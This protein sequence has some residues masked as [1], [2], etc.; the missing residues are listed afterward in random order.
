MPAVTLEIER[1]EPV[2]DGAAFGAAGP[3]EKIAG[4]LRFAID[5]ALPVH[6]T[7]AD[8]QLAPRNA[9]GRVESSAD[10]YLLRPVG[11]GNRR[12]LLDVPN[13]GRKMA[14]GMFNSTPRSN[15]PSN[16]EDF[17]NGFLMRHGYTVAWVGWQPDVP[18]QDGMMALTV[19]R[20]TGT[21]GRIRCEFRPNARTDSLPLADRY[22]IP[23]PVAQ[24]EDPEHELTVRAHAGAPDVPVPRSAWRFARA[25]GG[26]LVADRSCISLAGGFE[27]GKIYECYYRAQDPPVVGLGFT[28]VRD[29]AAFLR[30]GS[31]EAGNPCPGGLDRAYVF[32]VSQS[33]R[34]LRHLLYLGLDE[35]EAGR[36]VFDAVIPHVAGARR[37]EFNC[38]F[39]QPSLSGQRSIGSL[40][41]FADAEQEDPLTGQRG[42]L[43]ER[44]RRRGRVPKIFTINGSAE[45]WRG[46][47]S[48]VHT[49]VA[50]QRDIEPPADVRIYLFAGTQHTP[51]A[52][53]PPS[54]DANTGG[55]GRHMFSPVDYS[56]LLRAALVNLDL[57]VS[58]GTEPPG[59]MFPRIADG[60]A[61]AAER[62]RKVFDSIPGVA[63]PDRVVRPARLDFGAEVERGIISA[64]PPKVG[65]P[66]VTFVSAV[67]ADG[68]E[69][70]G[71]RPMEIRVPLATFTGWNPRHPDQGVP[72]DLMSMMGSTFPLARTVA[73]RD[74]TK[75]PRPSIGERYGDRAGYLERV[76]R[77]ADVMVA[78][79]FLLGEDVDAVVA[80][81]GLLWDF[82]VN[83][84]SSGE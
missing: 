65:A 14:L 16:R 41:P 42:G 70:A 35:D 32:G 51:G 3:Y 54:A 31:G 45:Y 33:G 15:D 63:F 50:G 66:F 68:N 71:I 48:L 46:D 79:R 62:T 67:D 73:E 43:L 11:G 44:L 18:R 39:G 82:I 36:A 61:V 22:H 75:D 53:P 27:P 78:A 2:L 58:E 38:R 34:F 8:I 81:A 9:H 12:L 80:R 5:P 10:F 26:A 47:G 64:L 49:D 30:F 74:R 84:T 4:V 60:T 83:R 25:E 56:P 21:T 55:R 23:Y 13:R 1:R 59:S 37:G 77:E 28:A 57:W 20:I 52:I 7:I 19:P 17:G 76:R 29:A 69:V 6:E 72:G 40:F 24:P